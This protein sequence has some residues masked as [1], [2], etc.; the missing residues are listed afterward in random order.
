[1]TLPPH[2][3]DALSAIQSY[4]DVLDVRVVQQSGNGTLL[5][6]ATFDTNLPT[7]W[8]AAGASRTGVRPTEVVEI[9]LPASF[10]SE[11]PSFTLRPDFNS[12][13][14]HI[15]PHDAGE[16]IPPCLFAGSN[17]E[18]L[19]SGG[20]Y[21]LVD[22]MAEWLRKAGRGQ[23]IDLSQ[24]WEPMRRDS[25]PDTLVFDPDEF[26]LSRSGFGRHVLYEA[27]S[28]WFEEGGA[29]LCKG[30]KKLSSNI[31]GVKDIHRIFNAKRGSNDVLIGT[32]LAVVCWPTATADGT[33][34][35]EDVYQPDTVGTL[36]GLLERASMLSCRHA[37]DA[38][39]GNLNYVSAGLENAVIYPIYI[40]LPVKRPTH[41][42]GL[43]S[44]FEFLAYKVI[45]NHQG[46]L[47]DNSLPVTPVSFLS[48]ISQE[49]LKRTSG[50]N[51]E[52]AQVMFGYLGCGSLGSKL[53][54]HAT[55]AGIPPAYLID[56]ER[57]AAHNVARHVLLPWQT[58]SL[59]SK[60]SELADMVQ[61][62]WGKNP[63][64]FEDDIRTLPFS[65]R[66]F[67]DF[68]LDSDM[69][70]VNTTGSHA[71]RE[72]LQNAPIRSRII[73]G[74]L[75]H[76]GTVGLLTVEG[77]Q[78]NPCSVD[79]IN[80]TYEVLRE[81]SKLTP[82]HNPDEHK[83][84]VGV[85]CNSVTMPMSDARISYFAAAMSQSL[86]TMHQHGL[87]ESGR[88]S[89]GLL[90]EDGLSLEW[91]TSSPGKTHSA[92]V[93]EDEGWS[94]RVLDGA[95]QKIIAETA[96][97]PSSETGGLIVGRVSPTS[98][99]ITI[100]NVLPAPSDSQRSSSQFVL[101]IDGLEENIRNYNETGAGVL[102]CLGTW[103]SHL[104]VSGPSGTDL[105]TAKSIQGLL[106]GAVVLLIRHPEG[107]A[108][109]VKSGAML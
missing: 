31:L 14:P 88:V 51:D 91:K 13:L 25:F 61:G 66:K 16:R 89:V 95:H 47:T 29:S 45:V 48:P 64:T 67:K 92:V 15:N 93:T 43:N 101:G 68:F 98:R 85:G 57:M 87:P 32:S 53:A 11:A 86:I 30:L 22:Q 55:R 78:Q 19:H 74:C 109:I 33:P 35:V 60:A 58:I 104:Q 107:Y 83:L 37:F 75:T 103:H 23:L 59:N 73:E 12:S 6:E 72:Y 20:M 21:R 80:A 38:F 90:H 41:V 40:I 79:L 105:N 3:A 26:I 97:Y 50:L 2:L 82:L 27:S 5:V 18:L 102:W 54:M 106:R 76:Q 49:L 56:N 10:P 28:L 42:I 24:G 62:F 1:M 94:V 77:P 34:Q 39:L 17:L 63:C 69:A 96:L 65:D 81:H 71:V 36:G 4:P 9:T 84:Q 52:S 7:R 44:D 108:A 46:M 99:E 100:T 70:L 8:K